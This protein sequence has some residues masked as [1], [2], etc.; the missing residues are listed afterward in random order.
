MVLDKGVVRV[1]IVVFVG[2]G[3]LPRRVEG[4]RA[5]G[6]R[7]GGLDETMELGRE[8]VRERGW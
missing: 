2:R 8:S 5:G 6:S 7:A 4:A 3:G 1:V